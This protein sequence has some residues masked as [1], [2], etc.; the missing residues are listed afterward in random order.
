MTEKVPEV[1]FRCVGVPGL[2][3]RM[4]LLSEERR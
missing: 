2:L 3:R 4:R 1:E